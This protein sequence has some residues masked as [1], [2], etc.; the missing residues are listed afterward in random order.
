MGPNIFRVGRAKLIAPE[1]SWVSLIKGMSGAPCNDVHPGR[2]AG[3]G[4]AG[5]VGCAL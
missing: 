5:G 1:D 4:D 3:L 2:P